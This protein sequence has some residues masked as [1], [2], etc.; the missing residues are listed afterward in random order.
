[1]TSF[2]QDNYLGEKTVI[3]EF[4]AYLSLKDIIASSGR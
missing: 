4:I 1:M 3:N 2:L